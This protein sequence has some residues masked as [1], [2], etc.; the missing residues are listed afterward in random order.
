MTY[1]TSA[2][3]LA[4]VHRET[5]INTQATATGA[6]QIR[7][8]DS[9]GV[10]LNRAQVQ[11]AEKLATGLKSMGRLGYKSVDGSIDSEISVG[12]ATDMFL[13]AIMR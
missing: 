2:N 10:K 8:I 5:S 1:Q 4:A 11:S 12:G 3:V 9:Q 7:I 6:T 13:E